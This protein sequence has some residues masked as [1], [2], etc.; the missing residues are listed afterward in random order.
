MSE[1]SR[2]SA[3]SGESGRAQFGEL[4]ADEVY[5]W[6]IPLDEGDLQR[7]RALLSQDEVARADRFVRAIDGTRFAEGRAAMRRI[8]AGYVGSSPQQLGFSYSS[9]GKPELAGRWQSSKIQFNLSHSQSIAL[10]AV[11]REREVGIDVEWMN[12]KTSVMEISERFF[13]KDEVAALQ[14]FPEEEQSLAFFQCWTRKEAFIK[15][16]GQ[17]LAIPLDSFD[18]SFGGKQAALLKSVR[19]GLT[20]ASRWKL[21]DLPIDAGYAAALAAEGDK[22]R[23]QFLRWISKDGE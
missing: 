17:G 3:S 22:H 20:D 21:Y 18:V 11:S 4:L 7:N 15:A 14:A 6:R 8:L 12:P 23:L 2:Q 19:S 13:S 5:I 10:L 1:E 16:L 9:S